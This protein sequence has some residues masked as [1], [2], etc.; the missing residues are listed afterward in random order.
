MRAIFK[1]KLFENKKNRRENGQS[2]VEFA[3]TLPLV[4]L[5]LCGI[6]EF[7]WVYGNALAVQ[8]ATREGVRAG[9]VASVEAENNTLVTNKILSMVPDA[10]LDVTITIVYSDTVNFQAGDITVTVNYS[11]KG[12]TPFATLFTDDGIFDLS[13]ECTMKMS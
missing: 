13:T 7:G 6:F 9:I 11:I 4:L 2:M 3:L 1:K 5:L 12:I 8:N 10:A